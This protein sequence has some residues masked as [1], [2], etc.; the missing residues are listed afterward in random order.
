[1]SASLTNLKFHY[2]IIATHDF[3]WVQTTIFHI[4]NA[5]Q[6]NEN[7]IFFTFLIFFLKDDVYLRHIFYQ[8]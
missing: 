7:F 8:R 6:M 1:M 4:Y 3:K 2:L 5:S